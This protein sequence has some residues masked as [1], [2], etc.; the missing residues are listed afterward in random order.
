ME[1]TL[2]RGS[3]EVTIP[4]LGESQDPIVNVDFGKPELQIQQ[5]GASD[6]RA[7]DQ[8]SGVE[9]YNLLG[10][11]TTSNAYQNAIDLAEL[12]KGYS[13]GE[14]M[15]L[16]IP[17]DEFDSNIM[18]SPAAGQDESVSMTYP[19]GYTERVDLDLS[20][21]RV[22]KT[23]GDGSQEETTPTATGTGPIQFKYQNTTVDLS[24]N[25]EVSRGVGRPNSSV[26]RSKQTYPNY[27]DKR[28]AAYDAFELSF[29]F[30]ENATDT[31][32]SLVND[33]FKP[34]SG[35][36]GIKLDFNGLYG[37]G[38]FAVVPDGTQAIRY[39]R[40][41]GEQ[42]ISQVPTVNVRRILTN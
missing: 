11:Y 9:S 36:Q 35:R 1:A 6:P 38:E 37:L 17:M 34:K 28:K 3:T 27:F 13:G 2:T 24:A 23:F 21:T 39:Q 16:N 15:Y 32:T 22:R 26:D 25:V 18:V 41:S 10:K 31:I 7:M 30:V 14:P 4:L 42:G 29:E 8:W 40:I 12:I 20:L 33:I 19:A 5:T